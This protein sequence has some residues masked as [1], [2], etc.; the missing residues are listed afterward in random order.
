M[1]M[2]RY[3]LLSLLLMGAGFAATRKQPGHRTPRKSPTPHFGSPKMK[4]HARVSS[5]RSSRPRSLQNRR[6]PSSKGQPRAHN[7]SARAQ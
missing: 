4:S 1:R 7:R 6:S 5:R 2:L 3:V